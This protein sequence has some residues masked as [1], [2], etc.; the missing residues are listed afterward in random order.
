LTRYEG[1]TLREIAFPLGG[2]GTG[3]IA[4]GG[5]AEL[6]DFE[7][8]NRPAKGF[9]PP[10][11]FFALRA[12]VPGQLAVTRVLEGVLRPPYGGS[13]GV[14]SATAGLPRMRHVSLEAAYPFALYSLS[15]PDIPLEVYLEVFNPL[16][17]LEVDRSSL[18]LAV[19]R[20]LLV[21]PGDRPVQASI[22]GSLLN[23]IGAEIS[24]RRRGPSISPGG[25]GALPGGNVND[26][27]RTVA[28]DGTPLTGLLM[29]SERVQ[30][31][32]PEDGTMALVV[33]AEDATWRRT[34]GPTH[35][36][37]HLLTF[38]DD[39][40][41]DGR[42]DDPSEVL[43][44]PE[45]QGQIGSVGA[46]A[47]VEP[48]GETT[49]TFLLCWHFPHRTAAG[50]GWDT[51]DER[52]GWIGNYYAKHYADAWDVALQIV[53]QLP[54]LEE[55]SLRFTRAFVSSDLPQ[56]VK[57]AALNN[58]STLRSQ[59]CFRTADGNF[60]GFEGCCDDQGCCF[61]SCTHVWNYEQTTAFLFPELA[62]NM[63]EL[64]L[65]WGTLDSGQNCFRLR[66]PLGSEPWAHAAADGQMGVVMKCYRE[67]QLS[68]DS[69]FLMRHWPTIK[70][71][72]SY[73]WLPGGWDAD[74]NG[75]MEGVQH[76]TYDVEFFGPNPLTGIWYLGALRAAEEMAKAVGDIQFARR[77][78]KLFV[79]GSGWIDAHLFNGEYYSHRI[80]VPS[81][82]DE[83]RPE[84]RAG[85]GET[86][87]AD[88]DF[89]LGNGCLV[90]QLVGQYMAHIVGLGYLLQPEKVKTALQSLFRYN[91]RQG[92]YD[93]WNNMRTFALA[94]E[95]ALLICSWPHGDRPKVPF[96]YFT[97]VMTGFEY[98]AAAHM[99][100]EGLVEEGLTVIDAIRARFDGYRRN[101]WN[102]QECGHHYAR[103][104]ASWAA[105][106][107][108]SG[109][110]YS[111]VSG[112]L[113]LAPRW[114]AEALR[115]VWM[116]PSGWGVVTQTLEAEEQ[117]VR[118]EVLSG[119]LAVQSM[120][121]MLPR[122][123]KLRTIALELAAR[124]EAARVE[125]RDSLVD[126]DLAQ[127]LNVTADQPLVVR[128]G[129]DR[130]D[131]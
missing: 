99:I 60:F 28:S 120:R 21:N 128:M 105:L 126:I 59:T 54:Q 14:S 46:T 9:T 108:L 19:L 70:S 12:Q 57:E 22:A 102:E 112:Q 89:Q 64:E 92:L 114:R 80:Q 6:R 131:L 38:W 52:G 33:L 24:C 2:I 117:T 45:G 82:L 15:D 62:R 115:C 101:P 72:V 8:C 43:P 67:W 47:W 48:Q 35:W 103:A 53:P 74:Q 75:V 83:T 41:T 30:P 121:Y 100:Y 49:F 44:S 13:F 65:E 130:T 26:V 113:Q 118:W 119:E 37:R 129:L 104:M 3:T 90:D 73:C 36:N 58:V 25:L 50:C 110:H 88:P 97:E 125:Q 71:L 18:P 91:F 69:D 95:S 23:F 79:Q 17:P 11:T 109:F 66:L 61:G 98:Q 124:V 77:C 84:L 16:I 76:N 122:G 81:S 78:R 85:M 5:R 87:L 123:A 68:D 4:L 106:L 127:M 1:D 31:R 10:Y 96:P 32:T 42:F 56:S 29:R 27:R 93:H 40:S 111:A 86:D 51:L 55:D 39:F 7:I 63:R 116:I 107:A 94:D 34:W 20:Y